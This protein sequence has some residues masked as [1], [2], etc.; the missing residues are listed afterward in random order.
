VE[1]YEVLGFFGDNIVTTEFDEWKPHR[2]I[3][4]PAFSEVSGFQARQGFTPPNYDSQTNK[5][6][7]FEESVRAITQLFEGAWRGKQEIAVDNALDLT[8]AV[9]SPMW[10]TIG[11]NFNKPS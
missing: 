5:K 6:L 7:A 1:S 8:M 3:A 9:S 2:K 10:V 11:E 4:A